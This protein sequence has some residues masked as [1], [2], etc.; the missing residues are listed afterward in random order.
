MTYERPTE[1]D[2]ALE[3][4]ASGGFTILAGGTDFYP[5][6]VAKPLAEAVLDISALAGLRG[7]TQPTEAGAA[8]SAVDGLARDVGWR[9]GALTTWTDLVRQARAPELKALVGAAREVGGLQIQNQGTVGGNLC[10]ASPAADGVPALAAL[11]AQVELR[12]RR[13]QRRLSVQEFVRGNRLTALADDEL[14]TAVLLPRF[15]ARARSQ[16]S[17]IGHRKYLVISIAS[18]AVCV[19]FDQHD[20]LSRCGIA[21]GSCAPS[22]RR[23]SAIETGLLAK[24]RAELLDRLDALLASP[25]ALKPLSPIDDVRGSAQYR[26][27]AVGELV[28]RLFQEL[29]HAA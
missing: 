25:D 24:P 11:D 6:R 16:F 15:S 8:G 4:R 14:L 2:R 18:V 13:G 26:L 23:L 29:I 17:K 28:R 3:L 12:S 1:L 21:V 9:I 19:D 27:A 5:A 22:V 20:R 10:N 7:M